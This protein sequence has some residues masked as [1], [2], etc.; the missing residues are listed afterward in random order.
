MIVWYIPFLY[1]FNASKGP[2]FQNLLI[3]TAAGVKCRVAA[4]K[5]FPYFII[6]QIIFYGILGSL[7]PCLFV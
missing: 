6:V 2:P 5:C 4:L 1:D 3:V 7:F